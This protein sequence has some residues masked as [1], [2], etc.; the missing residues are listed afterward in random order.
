MEPMAYE[1]KQEKIGGN[2]NPEFLFPNELP[3]KIGILGLLKQG[4]IMYNN[5]VS[6]RGF[7]QFKVLRFPA[8]HSPEVACNA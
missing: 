1:P 6:A 5:P 7:L 3:L 2:L 8:I 4:C